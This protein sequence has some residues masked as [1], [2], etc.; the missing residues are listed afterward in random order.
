MKL[1]V[2]LFEQHRRPIGPR[3]ASDGAMGLASRKSLVP[4][5]R[6]SISPMIGV[7]YLSRA[8]PELINTPHR[9]AR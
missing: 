8:A 1:S 5:G 2:S 6:V 7:T 9:S 3:Y 4:R